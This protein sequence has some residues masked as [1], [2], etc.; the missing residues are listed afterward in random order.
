MIK[1]ELNTF[2]NLHLEAI[3]WS[4]LI[5]KFQFKIKSILEF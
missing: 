1:N 5:E 2:D 3:K 4:G